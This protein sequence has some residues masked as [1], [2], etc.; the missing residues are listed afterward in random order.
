[1]RQNRSKVLARERAINLLPQVLPVEVSDAFAALPTDVIQQL[2][3]NMALEDIY[4]TCL[5]SRRFNIIICNNQKFWTLL[6]KKNFSELATL[7]TVPSNEKLIIPSRFETP[8]NF[9]RFLSGHTVPEIYGGYTTYQMLMILSFL[10]N[11]I[12]PETDEQR[13]ARKSTGPLRLITDEEYLEILHQAE[14]EFI[15]QGFGNPG[16]AREIFNFNNPLQAGGFNISTARPETIVY[17]ANSPQSRIVETYRPYI[18][19]RLKEVIYRYL[20]LSAH[21]KVLLGTSS[22]AHAEIIKFSVLMTIRR[23]DAYLRGIFFAHRQYL[24]LKVK[25]RSGDIEDKYDLCT[26]Q[27]ILD[28]LYKGFYLSDRN[29]E[30]DREDERQNHTRKDDL[31]QI[32]SHFFQRGLYPTNFES[33]DEWKREREKVLEKWN[34][35]RKILR[36]PKYIQLSDAEKIKLHETLLE[37]GLHPVDLKYLLEEMKHDSRF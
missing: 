2:A 37:K 1:M 5:T 14:A 6:I 35:V 18:Y 11:V 36:T 9:Y 17:R 28:A 33:L 34:M 10:R 27:Y 23:I 29:S 21:Q 7:L 25:F 4:H 13:S 32:N 30:P 15:L 19:D 8:K 31:L 26:H 22:V 16:A 24:K 20:V 3:L 12:I